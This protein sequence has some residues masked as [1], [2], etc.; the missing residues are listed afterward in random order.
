[1]KESRRQFIKTSALAS[2]SLTLSSMNALTSSK[3][4]NSSGFDLAFYLTAWGFKGSYDEMAKAAK[5][6]G[7][8]GI[9]VGPPKNEKKREEFFEA[10]H[11]YGISYSGFASSGKSSSFQDHLETYRTNLDK[12]IAIKPHHINCHAGKD[13]FTFDQNIKL[14]K[15]G[16]KKSKES[17]IPIYQETHRGRALFAAHLSE[18]YLKELKELRLTLDI[19]HWCNVAESLLEDQQDIV[20]KVLKRVDNIHGRVGFHEGP[21]VPDFRAPEW[22]KATNAHFAW[23]DKVVT[24]KKEKGELLTVTPEFGPKAYMWQ[25]PYTQQPLADQFK[26]NVEMMNAW[27]KRYL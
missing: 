22:K 6:E 5:K 9:A 21:Q 10:I 23:W 12:I 20:N 11:K 19:S 24:L 3:Y 13:Y 1:M 16:I 15:I 27:K 18:P 2:A 7:Y 14:F 25:L 8:N 17:G 4:L 26:M